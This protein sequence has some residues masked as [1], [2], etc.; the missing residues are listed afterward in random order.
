MKLSLFLT[1]CCLCA[2]LV[3]L[4]PNPAQ[5]GSPIQKL[6]SS[7]AQGLNGVLP[8]I[9]VWAGAGANLNFV[10]TSEIVKKVW[11]D[12][13]SQITLDF[14]GSMCM[15]VSD[16]SSK[17]CENSATVIH[18]RRIHPINFP[19]LPQTGSTLLSVVTQIPGGERKLYQFRIV[20]GKGN[21]EY[22]AVAIYPDS[23]ANPTVNGVGGSF[24]EVQLPDIKQGL[25]VAKSQNLLGRNQGNQSLE[26]RV[27]SF[28]A[29]ANRG[30]NL[31][32]AASQS[33]LSMQLIHKLAE[34]GATAT[35][36]SV[37][38]NSSI[39]SA[40]A[41][42]VRQ[43]SITRNSARPVAANTVSNK[44]QL[45]NVS[46]PKPTILSP[47]KTPQQLPASPVPPQFSRARAIPKGQATLSGIALQSKI[48][49]TSISSSTPAILQQKVTNSSNSSS[50][51]LE[52]SRVTS[53][54]PESKKPVRTRGRSKLPAARALPKRSVIAVNKT[55][56]QAPRHSLQAI[57]DANAA[58][59]GLTVAKHK[60][61]IN[62]ATLTWK[63]AQGAIRQL[64][65]GKNREEAA[66]RSGIDISVL[67]QLI[68]WGQTRP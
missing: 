1:S 23:P 18:L 34:L 54:P 56:I 47:Q 4:P 25:Q 16:R 55:L 29:L 35:Q 59:F 46:L 48:T 39:P 65:L 61:Q 43:A 3:N 68:E 5:A 57:D 64:R 15:D 60:G 37:A 58:A 40:S 53:H 27:Q 22:H 51:R 7:Q 50:R 32:S 38:S 21:P 49:P 42:A 67:S 8:T 26:L 52:G 45:A 19:D 31:Q 13:P 66:R 63:K 10:P 2:S 20:Y 44:P 28:L 30:E 41:R 62:P 6:S 24:Q 11:L 17:S 9:T 14:D 36:A 33:G 12:D